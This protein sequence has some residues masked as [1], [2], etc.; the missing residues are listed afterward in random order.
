MNFDAFSLTRQKPLKKNLGLDVT[1]RKQIQ[2]QI[3][4]K[5]SIIWTGIFEGPQGSGAAKSEPVGGGGGGGGRWK[6]EG[7][8]SNNP[9][10]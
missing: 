5:T 1:G 3:L 10:R 9:I 2:I 4:G 6:H 8:K 7:E